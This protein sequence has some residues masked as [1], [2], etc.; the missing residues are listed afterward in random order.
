MDKINSELQFL[1]NS[2][3]LEACGFI[4]RDTTVVFCWY[5]SFGSGMASGKHRQ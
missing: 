5:A 3:R 2:A 1:L 4:I